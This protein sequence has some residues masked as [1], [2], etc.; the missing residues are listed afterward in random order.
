MIYLLTLKW[1]RKKVVCVCA[2]LWREREKER[3]SEQVSKQVSARVNYKPNG[4]KY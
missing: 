4:A 1:F 2:S 3:V